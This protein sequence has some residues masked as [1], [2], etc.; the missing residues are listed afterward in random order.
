M[1]SVEKA[2]RHG[3]EYARRVSVGERL[4]RVARD[5]ERRPEEA[6]EACEVA[7][8]EATD[9]EAVK[10]L[11]GVPDL[12]DLRHSNPGLVRRGAL[13]LVEKYEGAQVEEE[14][15]GAEDVRAPEDRVGD[16]VHPRGLVAERLDDAEPR[17]GRCS[18]EERFHA[19][20]RV[21]EVDAA[22]VI[23]VTPARLVPV[24]KF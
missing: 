24:W 21:V 8:P 16:A 1:L 20:G 10:V 4:G 17:V 22:R 9:A 18:G 15:L 12:V 7:R 19:L 6:K 23:R 14:V 2:R 11:P 5:A 13:I 3:H